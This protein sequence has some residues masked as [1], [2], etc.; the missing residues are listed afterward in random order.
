MAHREP[1][2]ASNIIVKRLPWA[3]AFG[4]VYSALLLLGWGLSDINGFFSHPARAVLFAVTVSANTL[5]MLF[6]D[7]MR[8]GSLRKGERE[9]PGERVIGIL[10]PVLVGFLIV[11]A[12]PYSDSHKVLVL[13]GGDL[14]RYVGLFLFLIGLVFMAWAP[15]HLGK[16]YSWHVTIQKE[17]RLVTDGPYGFI[18]HPRYSGIMLWVFGIALVFLSLPALMLASMMT[19]CMLSRIPKEEQLLH[20]EFGEEW[21]AYRERT[22][23]GMIPHIY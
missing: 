21:E 9:D 4:V 7:C 5:F 13:G 10:L 16:Q 15:L 19:L 23:R 14:L 17:H 3:L 12:A 1:R 11:F 18:R 8:L 20:D 2:T 22:P 6:S